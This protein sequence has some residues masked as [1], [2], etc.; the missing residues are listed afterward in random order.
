MK[1][2]YRATIYVT[3]YGSLIDY[4]GGWCSTKKAAEKEAAKVVE[5]ALPKG[6]YMMSNPMYA[7]RSVA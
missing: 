1:K 2:Q 4:S 3:I 7:E 6:I 5:N